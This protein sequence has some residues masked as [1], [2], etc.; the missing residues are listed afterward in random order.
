VVVLRPCS[1]RDGSGR[2]HA[3]VSHAGSVMPRPR[4]SPCAVRVLLR[5]VS[6]GS[7]RPRF[8]L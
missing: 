2:A 7:V 3:S 5:S 6:S 1:L 4:P 8:A